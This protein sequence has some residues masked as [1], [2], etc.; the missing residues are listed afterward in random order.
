MAMKGYHSYR[1]RP[2]VLRWLLT[3]ILVLILI[4]ACAFLFLQRYI[5]YSDDGS[6]YLDLPF[7]IKLD[8]PFF[9]NEET[10]D[11][12]DT[13]TGTDDEQDVN[14]VVDPSIE[15]PSEPDEPDE[16]TAPVEDPEQHEPSKPEPYANRHL[17]ELSQL[18]QDEDALRDALTAA[19]A[20]GFVFHA[21]ERWGKVNYTSQ[22]ALP[23]AIR[24]DAAATALLDRLC[25]QENVYTVARINCFHDSIY[26]K[27][28]MAETGICQSNGYIWYDYNEEH[29]M[30][31]EKEAARKYLIDMA[32]ECAQMGFD[33]LLLEEVCYPVYGKV[34][35][36]D[37]SKNQ[38]DKTD[39]LVLFLTELKDALEPY[40]VRLSLLMEESVIFG[41]AEDT[42][43]TGLIAEN[44]LP[45]VDAVYLTTQDTAAVHQAMETLLGGE[46]IPAL[47]PIVSE[48]TEDAAWYLAG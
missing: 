21:K 32:V 14:L 33:E 37:Y 13:D 18:P 3:I 16:P 27:A 29:W 7:E 23:D 42:Q 24:S 9:G 4:A 48:A 26:A 28:N 31:P 34:Y 45:L 46:N 12:P 25:A 1:G 40:G 20:D 43:H 2:G 47:V 19:G 5:T 17:I 15:N 8:M 41:T 6:F 30:D 22:I 44:L 36:I 35:K 39:A 38:M 11:T 10:E